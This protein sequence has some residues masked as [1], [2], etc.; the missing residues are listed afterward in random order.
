MA[1][2]YALRAE[3]WFEE[4]RYS[5]DD[6]PVLDDGMFAD[7]IR[8]S[9]SLDLGDLVAEP[10]LYVRSASAKSEVEAGSVVAYRDKDE[11]LAEMESEVQDGET[12]ALGAS[13]DENVSEWVGA[14]QGYLERAEGVVSFSELV[15]ELGMSVMVVWLGI[16]L[17]GFEV[18][19]AGGFYDE[20]I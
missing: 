1:E 7:L 20:V 17:G 14:I 19:Q 5:P 8:Q 16:L 6:E 12:I 2:V 18:Q 13:H 10:E 9:M 11:V 4:L 3:A 15:R